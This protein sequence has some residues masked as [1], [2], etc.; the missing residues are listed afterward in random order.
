MQSNRNPSF[1]PGD[2]GVRPISHGL[3]L[4]LEFLDLDADGTVLIEDRLAQVELAFHQI[5][6]KC[7]GGRIS[8]RAINGFTGYFHIEVW[9]K[10]V[11]LSL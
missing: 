7:G 8:K 5:R 1:V 11:P 9:Y 4:R 10:R 3:F 6:P 2:G